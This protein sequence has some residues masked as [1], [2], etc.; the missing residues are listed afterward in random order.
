MLRDIAGYLK[1]LDKSN[2]LKIEGVDFFIAGT[3]EDVKGETRPRYLISKMGCE[4]VANKLTGEKGVLFTA[5]YVARFNEMEAVEKSAVAALRSP[6]LGE[7][8]A[9]SRLIVRALKDAGATP[10]EILDFLRQVYEPLGFTILTCTDDAPRFYTPKQIAQKL[11]IYSCSG[12]PHTQAVAALLDDFDLDE[13][14]KAVL[15][16]RYGDHLSVSTRY[17][18]Y[19]ASTARALLED[20]GYPTEIFGKDRVYH[21]LYRLK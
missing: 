1:V 10:E 15:P 9:A 21:V 20:M 5:A 13:S 8:N 18:D 6:R 17:D 2:V 11:G 7:F 4:M 16:V 3:Y 14:H 19:A 12:R